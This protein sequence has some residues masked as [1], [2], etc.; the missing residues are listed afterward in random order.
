MVVCLMLYFCLTQKTDPRPPL[1]M[2]R[3]I[4]RRSGEPH[5]ALVAVAVSYRRR[6]SQ[7]PITLDSPA[8]VT[9]LSNAT[10]AAA[11]RTNRKGSVQGQAFAQRLAAFLLDRSNI[12]DNPKA[13]VFDPGVLFRKKEAFPDDN[14]IAALH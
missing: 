4:G 6:A 14:E 3:E 12:K 8:I 7:E 13:C 1:G 2:N 11:Y 10:E 5:I 9:L